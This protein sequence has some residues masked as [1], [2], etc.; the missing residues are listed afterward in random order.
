M[1]GQ[2]HCMIFLKD[3]PLLLHPRCHQT[4]CQFDQSLYSEDS[5]NKYEVYLPEKL[6]SAVTKR[7][8]EY[9]AGRYCAIQSLK[10]LGTPAPQDISTNENRS[11]NWPEGYIGSITHSKGF[12][13][14]AISEKKYIRAIGIDSELLIKER[15]ASNVHSHVLTENEK[16]DDNLWITGNFREYLTLVFS[17]KESIYKCLNPLVNQF[18]DFRDACISF[19]EN[20]PNEFSYTLLKTL[21]PEFSER[22]QGKGQYLIDGEFIHTG[23]IIDTQQP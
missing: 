7:K 11:P 1:L 18:F 15:T 10:T 21:S 9:I 16:H 17:A 23:T 13:S 14:A 3:N 22:F 12:A 4:S 19:D 8:A 6:E 2:I 20:K 5:A